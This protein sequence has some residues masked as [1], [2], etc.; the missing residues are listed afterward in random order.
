ME[1]HIENETD[2]LPDTIKRTLNLRNNRLPG[3]LI[4]HVIEFTSRIKASYNISSYVSEK[5]KKT[6]ISEQIAKLV[7]LLKFTLKQI[8]T[9][10]D[11]EHALA[12]T[13]VGSTTRVFNVRVTGEGLRPKTKG[14]TLAQSSRLKEN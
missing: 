11:D 13:W 6:N 7:A 4:H 8:A 2:I 9:S 12:D 10:R 14:A 1:I 3:K 5:T